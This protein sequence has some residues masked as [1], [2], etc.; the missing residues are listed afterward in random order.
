MRQSHRQ[1]GPLYLHEERWRQ[2]PHGR[3]SYPRR[4]TSRR[5]VSETRVPNPPPWVS[6]WALKLRPRGKTLPQPLP[7]TCHHCPSTV[8]APTL[9][10]HRPHFF[11]RWAC[12]CAENIAAGGEPQYLRMRTAKYLAFQRNANSVRPREHRHNILCLFFAGWD[13]HTDRLSLCV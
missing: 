13:G 4:A 6:P 5:L 9:P 12:T 11:G 10:A 7:K 1:G 3:R 2:P 8:P